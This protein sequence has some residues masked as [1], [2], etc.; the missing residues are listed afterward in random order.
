[1]ASGASHA[2]AAVMLIDARHG[3][4]PQTRRH[5]AILQLMG[6]PRVILAVNKMDLV[7][8]SEARFRQIE[9]DFLA[10]VAG[11]GFAEAHAIPVS[12]RHG[13]NIASASKNMPWYGGA[14]L[15]AHV[16]SMPSRQTAGAQPFRMPVQI[17]LRDGQDFRGLAGT[18]SSGSIRVGDEVA[19]TASGRRA[20][21]ERIATMDGDLGEAAKGKAAVLVL[22]TDLD[23]ARGA[24]LT[25]PHAPPV[26]ARHIEARL[27][28]L[29]ASPFAAS[30][31]LLLR[32]AA[33]LVPVSA[34]A[35]TAQ[36][37]LDTLSL[38][39]ANSCSVN[40]IVAASV[41]L[42][43]PAALDLFGEHQETGAFLLVDSLTGA[44]LAAGVAVAAK[45]KDGAP[46]A[47]PSFLLTRAMLARGL[48]SDLG[49]GEEDAP[50]FR[51]R[52]R[53]VL[54]L[55]ADAGVAAAY[56]ESV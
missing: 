27:V 48:C 3:L 9:R 21:V 47:P 26:N 51:R 24:V 11:L 53:E 15:V 46:A 17:V 30:H 40:D 6:V 2:D 12:A 25:A 31:G 34:M 32:T 19:D 5:A 22:D 4:K 8:W 16:E 39:P 20:R 49:G 28:W 18:V 35:I 55:L 1:M 7:D 33:D 45:A 23:I 36:V 54:R 50:E 29:A 56:E 41:T 37:D 43:R 38:K 13:D 44:T 52:A 42:G 10:A 14:P